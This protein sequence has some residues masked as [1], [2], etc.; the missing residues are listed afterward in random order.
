MTWFSTPHRHA[1][2]KQAIL[3]G[4]LLAEKRVNAR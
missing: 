3:Q 2:S 4:Y 1:A